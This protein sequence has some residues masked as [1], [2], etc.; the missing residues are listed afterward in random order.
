MVINTVFGI[1][2]IDF[3]VVTRSPI[4]NNSLV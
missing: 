2:T 4:W 1:V 3:F